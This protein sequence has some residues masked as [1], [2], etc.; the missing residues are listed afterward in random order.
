M[1]YDYDISISFAGENRSIA[2]QIA[3]ILQEYSINVFYDKFE[4]YDLIGKDLATHL[5]DI[6]SKRARYC[7][8]LIS[9]YYPQKKWPSNIELPAVRDRSFQQDGDYILPILLDDTSIPGLPSTIGCLDLRNTSVENIAGDIARK[10]LL[11]RYKLAKTSKNVFKRFF[12]NQ[13][14]Y[15]NKETINLFCHN[16]YNSHT[17]EFRFAAFTL[18]QLLNNHQ[19][20]LTLRMLADR[21][22]IE[23]RDGT[24]RFYCLDPKD[25]FI[26][27]FI[28]H[29]RDPID[30]LCEKL[31][32]AYNDVQ[33]LLESDEF[34]RRFR[35]QF[36]WYRGIPAF[37]LC[38]IGNHYYMRSY[39]LGQKQDYYTVYCIVRDKAPNHYIQCLDSFFL[40]L[41]LRSRI[42]TL[43][44]F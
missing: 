15:N 13:C 14:T 37:H 12:I 18:V 24:F 26:N 30:S 42:E 5:P 1:T 29:S 34:R 16:L 41:E 35:V 32:S 33:K 8:V 17:T 4:Q 10:V 9:K 31:M 3:R 27:E 11:E 19:F 28:K 44:W 20:Q 23:N 6:F 25:D 39:T 38:Q 43:N 40:D 7:V 36:C 21:M 2:E 22:R